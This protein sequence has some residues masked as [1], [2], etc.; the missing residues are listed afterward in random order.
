MRSQFRLSAIWVIPAEAIDITEQRVVIPPL[1]TVS[2][3]LTPSRV[4]YHSTKLF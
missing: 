4:R 3:S 1:W 2:K